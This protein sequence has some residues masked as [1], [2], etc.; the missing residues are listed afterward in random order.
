MGISFLMRFF[1]IDLFPI[2]VSFPCIRPAFAELGG[3][4]REVRC[5]S[6]RPR[7]VFGL[8]RDPAVAGFALLGPQEKRWGSF[9]RGGSLLY[10]R[11]LVTLA[12]HIGQHPRVQVGH[13]RFRSS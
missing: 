8:G 4:L 2:R 10:L 13:Y 7:G 11:P 12:D 1:K 9:G 5:V 6:L 3:L